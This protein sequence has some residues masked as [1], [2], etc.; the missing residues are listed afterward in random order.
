[1][2]RCREQSLP[3]DGS[4][5]PEERLTAWAAPRPREPGIEQELRRTLL[6]MYRQGTAVPDGTDAEGNPTFRFTSS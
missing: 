5:W 6:V 3:T 2:R 4:E 1:M